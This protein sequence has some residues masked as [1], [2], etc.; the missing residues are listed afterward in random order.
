MGICNLQS[1]ITA[2]DWQWGDVIPV[3]AS[4]FQYAGA[5]SCSPLLPAWHL[6]L[7]DDKRGK[8]RSALRYPCRRMLLQSPRPSRQYF[9]TT[10]HVAGPG[11]SWKSQ[12]QNIEVW[13]IWWLIW[14]LHL[15]TIMLQSLHDSIVCSSRV[16]LG[17]VL[18]NNTT[19]RSDGPLIFNFW[20]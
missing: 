15:N 6:P 7:P 11:W 12:F 20:D 9:L 1:L 8:H 19:L 13:N 2:L 18:L 14:K 4:P 16:Q 3:E 10:A 5:Y 17:V